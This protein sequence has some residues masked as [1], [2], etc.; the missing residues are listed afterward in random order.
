MECKYLLSAVLN[1]LGDISGA[2]ANCGIGMN[3]SGNPKAGCP[4]NGANGAC[5]K[6]CG[7]KLGNGAYGNAGP[8][9]ASPLTV[10]KVP[11]GPLVCVYVPPLPSLLLLEPALADVE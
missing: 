4:L 9:T 2:G 8:Y 1:S 7:T 6:N 10:V 11:V 5:G 3:G